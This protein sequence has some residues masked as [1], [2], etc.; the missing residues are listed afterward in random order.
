[1]NMSATTQSTRKND[2]GMV[3]CTWNVPGKFKEATSR[4]ALKRIPKSMEFN[5]TYQ[6]I[7]NLTNLMNNI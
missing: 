3:L 2:S 5:Y 6:I 4:A 7:I 1:M